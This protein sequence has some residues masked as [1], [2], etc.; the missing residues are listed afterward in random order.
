[1]SPRDQA[2]FWFLD[3]KVTFLNHGSFGSCPRPVL[4]RQTELRE[5]MEREPVLFLARE[6]PA[7]LDQARYALA[8]FL[9]ADPEGL[10]FV[11]N[12]TMGVNTVLHHFPLSPGDELLTTDH[13]YNACRN[14]LEFRARSAAARVTVAS[15]P[16]PVSGPEQVVEAV[17]KRVTPRT[18]LVLLDHVTSP[19]ALVFP[20]QELARLLAERGIP[21]LVDG[22]HAPGL[23]PMNLEEI[24]APFYT[25]NAHKWLSAPKGAAFLW[26]APEWRER[27]A[28]LVISHGYND[29]G[30]ASRFR[31]LFDWTG[32]ADP[33]PFLAIPEALR[34]IGRL[35]PGGW[36]ELR[37]RNNELVLAGREMLLE[38][39]GQPA[40]APREMLAAM[41]AVILPPVPEIRPGRD[42]WEST[43]FDRYQIEVPVIPW[44]APPRRL[45]RISAQAY[46]HLE[47][48]R[49]LADRLGELVSGAAS[50]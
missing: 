7:L 28:P 10:V 49:Q 46:N 4:E 14:V 26:V 18:R 40:P 42:P 32:T 36:D 30:P 44:P 39:L 15:V 1:M 37:R 17:L 25:G 16:F 34:Q 24:G 38:V 23:L 27:I 50:G 31:K 13:A 45:L 3:P 21:L 8:E 48:Y 6:L 9:G 29:P 11:T 5:R 35:F 22:A 43:L 12:A 2:P 41:A 33:T 47:Q 19:T 20:V